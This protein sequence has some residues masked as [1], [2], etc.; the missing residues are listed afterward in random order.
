MDSMIEV[1]EEMHRHYALGE[2]S[3]SERRNVTIGD[4]GLAI[5]GGGLSYK[6]LFGAKTYTN[7]GGRQQYHV[8]LY[9]A[10]SGRLLAFL[11]AN[12]LGALRTGATTGVAV[13]HLA[14]ADAGVLGVIGTGYQAQTQIMAVA[15][16]RNLRE[17][18]VFSRSPEPRVAFAQRMSEVLGQ[19]VVAAS[20][21]REAVVGSDIVV[22][23]TTTK[24]PVLKGSWLKE[25]AL[26]VSAGPVSLDAQEVDETSIKRA[27]RIFVDSLE[28]APYE[29]GELVAAVDK[30]I[31][32]WDRVAELS[33]VIAGQV[34]GRSN[35]GEN[36]YVKHFGIGVADIAA[37]KLAYDAAREKG[38]GLEVDM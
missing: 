1:V 35:P 32:T 4:S 24:D 29:A 8:T 20:S 11:H 17:I 21:N 19:K 36:I 22:C 18:K 2:A 7:A 14:N 13:R 16:T 3:N 28:Q 37:S 30:G 26:L 6:G 15:R 12:W 38:R 5:M 34:Q 31:I 10:A 25:G 27:S 23:L 33:Q 9:D